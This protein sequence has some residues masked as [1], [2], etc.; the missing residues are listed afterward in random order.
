MEPINV[1]G[2]CN[3]CKEA[4]RAIDTSDQAIE[5]GKA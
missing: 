1:W 2:M 3:G 5:Q 4:A